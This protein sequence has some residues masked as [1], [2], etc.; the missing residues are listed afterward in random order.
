MSDAVPTVVVEIDS[1]NDLDKVAWFIT[2][3]LGGK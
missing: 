2:E 3:Y 1:W